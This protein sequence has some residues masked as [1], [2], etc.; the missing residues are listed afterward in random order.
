MAHTNANL[1]LH[2]KLDLERAFRYLESIIRLEQLVFF[3]KT[4]G[5]EWECCDMYIYIYIYV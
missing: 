2:T 3:S 1:S 5:K 4:L